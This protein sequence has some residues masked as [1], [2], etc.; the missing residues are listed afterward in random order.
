MRA[1]VTIY[2]LRVSIIMV[3]GA[4]EREHDTCILSVMLPLLGWVGF[5][6]P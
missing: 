3:T 4:S 2:C 5:L 6:L 1:C